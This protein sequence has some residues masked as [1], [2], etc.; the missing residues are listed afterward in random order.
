MNRVNCRGEALRRG[1]KNLMVLKNMCGREE[2]IKRIELPTT[3]IN[4]QQRF[5]GYKIANRHKLF[6]R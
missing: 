2:M 3:T 5:F 6:Y 1:R 4:R